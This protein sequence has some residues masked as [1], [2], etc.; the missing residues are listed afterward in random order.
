MV[1]RELRS[2]RVV[3]GKRLRDHLLHRT[4]HCNLVGQIG[5]KPSI[6]ID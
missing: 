3:L 2:M 5:S 1:V 4:S 6:E